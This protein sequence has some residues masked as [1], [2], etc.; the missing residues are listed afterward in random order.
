MTSEGSIAA[1]DLV[2]QGD[3]TWD[4]RIGGAA[5]ALAR[6]PFV[7]DEFMPVSH[8]CADEDYVERMHFDFP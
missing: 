4:V 7:K 8:D 6:V 5:E 3:Q 2:E 1:F